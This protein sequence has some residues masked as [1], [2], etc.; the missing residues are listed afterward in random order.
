[1]LCA[2]QPNVL[3]FDDFITRTGSGFQFL[4]IQDGNFATV[5]ANQSCLLKAVSRF[6][7]TRTSYTQ[8]LGDKFMS[9]RQLV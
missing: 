6:R 1:V 8:H 4:P 5:V 3:A 7:D 2:E 9:Q